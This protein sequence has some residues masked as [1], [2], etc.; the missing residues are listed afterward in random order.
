MIFWFLISALGLF[1]SQAT[2]GADPLIPDVDH[3]ADPGQPDAVHLPR[4]RPDVV[5]DLPT[6]RNLRRP[7]GAGDRCPLR[8]RPTSAG[9][10][11]RSTA[12]TARA[13]VDTKPDPIL[14]AHNIM[15]TFGGLIAVDVEHVEIQRGRDH[16]AD[17]PQRR[18]QDHVLQPAHLLRPPGRRRLVVQRQEPEQGV[19]RTKV[20]RLRHDPHLPADQGAVQADGHREHAGRRRP[21]RRG[22]TPAGR[23]CSRPF[24]RSAGEGQHRRRPTRCSSGSC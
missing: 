1:F 12:S 16:R 5:D 17:R 24:W 8:A 7:K 4:S 13:G 19:R 2:S 14:V 9:R 10:P 3:D 11:D 18:R 23:R 15:R 22:E 21:A 6:T 20:A